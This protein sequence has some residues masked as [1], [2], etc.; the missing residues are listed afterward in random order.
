MVA[1]ALIVWGAVMLYAEKVAK[2]NRPES[3]LNLTDALL[4]GF[5]QSLA[6]IPGVSRSG[7]T[8]SVGLMRGLDRVAA[9]RLAFFLGIPALLGAG[10]YE[11]PSAL[12]EGVGAVPTVVGTVVSFVVAYA[13][14]AW[15]MKYVSGHKITVF[16]WYRWA[17]GVAADRRTRRRLDR[18]RPVTTADVPPGAAAP[19]TA[20]PA[21]AATPP[22]RQDGR[23][24][25]LL[26]HARSTANVAG[27][28]AG[29]ST[30][31]VAGRDG[32]RPGDRP[33]RSGW[34]ACTSPGSFRHR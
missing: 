32:R 27:V 13:S 16:V 6:L 18:G 20:A 9:T 17:L 34:P 21:E 23:T 26:R 11:L 10:V 7:A 14:V 1:V 33:R 24:V 12:G 31:V 19:V 15:L 25:I 28:L 29:R 30:G 8:I 5:A 2:Q 4:I 3:D 22:P